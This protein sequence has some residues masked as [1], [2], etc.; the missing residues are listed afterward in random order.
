MGSIDYSQVPSPQSIFASGKTAFYTPAFFVCGQ[1][2]YPKGCAQTDKNNFAPRVGIVWSIDPK[3]VIRAGGGV[4]YANTDANPLF[5]LAA[6][7]P[8]N[9]AQTLS[10]TTYNPKNQGYNIFGPG[11][12]GPSQIQA[13][14]IDINQR[15]SYSLQWNASVQRQLGKNIVLEAGYIATLGIKLEQNVQPNNA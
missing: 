13:A 1:S 12:V 10:I 6:G 14:G 8:D 4:F 9:I 15:T 5:R 3:T 11:V 2:G 7:L